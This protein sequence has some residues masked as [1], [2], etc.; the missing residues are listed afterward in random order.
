MGITEYIIVD[1]FVVTAGDSAGSQRTPSIKSSNTSS[2]VVFTIDFGKHFLWS[3]LT[4]HEMFDMCIC[5]CMVN[6]MQSE[7]LNSIFV[8]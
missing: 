2:D 6:A 3:P 4:F 7:D 1:V 5:I 8:F